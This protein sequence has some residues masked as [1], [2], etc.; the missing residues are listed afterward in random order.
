VL[1]RDAHDGQRPL[2]SRAGAAQLL[3]ISIDTFDRLV[4]PEVRAVRIGRR[5]LF[6]APD[7]ARWVEEHAAL[8][9]AASLPRD[10]AGPCDG[11]RRVAK[12]GRSTPARRGAMVRRTKKTRAGA[13][14]DPAP[15][16]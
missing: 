12:L 3:S 16:P 13:G 10:P 7:L 1:A 2:V 5:V 9:L 14:L 6:S 8:P 15:S 4:M 11:Y